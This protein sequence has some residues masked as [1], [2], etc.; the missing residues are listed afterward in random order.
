MTSAVPILHNTARARDS[1]A[2]QALNPCAK[3]QT[4]EQ[5]SYPQWRGKRKARRSGVHMQPAQQNIS[6]YHFQDLGSFSSRQGLN[7]I[8][9]PQ[10]AQSRCSPSLCR[11]SCLGL[12]DIAIVP[13]LCCQHPEEP[14]TLVHQKTPTWA[15]N[16]C[17]KFSICAGS[18]GE[19]RLL[20]RLTRRHV[21]AAL[22]L[23]LGSSNQFV[24]QKIIFS[25]PGNQSN[26]FLIAQRRVASLR[27]TASGGRRVSEPY[28]APKLP[29]SV[30]AESRP[31]YASSPPLPYDVSTFS[32]FFDGGPSVCS[33]SI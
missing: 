20:L 12:F 26:L 1:Q 31:Q 10:P 29:R 30:A 8:V 2:L 24:D 19:T 32:S 18:C 9:N 6:G 33:M 17:S 15:A 21:L 11:S 13:C 22:C 16:I 7:I 3:I 14:E 23:Q 5:G 4:A 28:P 27:T 25:I